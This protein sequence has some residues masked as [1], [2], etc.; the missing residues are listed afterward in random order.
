MEMLETSGRIDFLTPTDTADPR[1]STDYLFG[2]ARG[3]MFGV[4]V[5]RR[6]D[7][8]TTVLRAFSGQYDGVWEVGG[9]VG[10]LFDVAAMDRISADVEKSIKKLGTELGRLEAG[11]PA[12]NAL[13]G[14]RKA[15]SRKLM[16]EMHG[17]YRLHNFRG[18]TRPLAAVF[19]GANGIPTGTGDCCAPKLLNHAACKGLTPVGLAEFYWGSENLSRTR[20]HGRFYPSCAGKCRPI[21]G[22]MLCGLGEAK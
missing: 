7:G 12:R 17:A 19:A 11:S 15:M 22:F 18:E 10:P 4:L 13:I 14:Q 9:W 5:C 3:Q 2:A 21:L 16:R 6:P 20:Q 8:M 1:F